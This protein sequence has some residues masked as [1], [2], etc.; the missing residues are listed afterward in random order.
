MIIELIHAVP[1]GTFDSCLVSFILYQ[2]D[3]SSIEKRRFWAARLRLE[4]YYTGRLACTYPEESLVTT[5]L[6]QVTIQFTPIYGSIYGSILWQAMEEC[7]KAGIKVHVAGQPWFRPF[8]LISMI[9][10]DF[11]V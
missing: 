5:N 3:D 6:I 1:P 2:N 8:R 4:P 10:A 7:A 9:G 11:T